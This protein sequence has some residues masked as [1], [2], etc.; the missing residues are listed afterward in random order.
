MLQ[1]TVLRALRSLEED[2]KTWGL[3][4]RLFVM[5]FK[6]LPSVSAE[7]AEELHHVYEVAKPIADSGIRYW[8][9]FVYDPAKDLVD[10]LE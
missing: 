5:Q 1:L 8:V 4:A 10:M 7:V 9:G 6:R 3:S 2:I